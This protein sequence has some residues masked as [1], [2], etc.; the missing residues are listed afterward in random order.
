[1]Y[2]QSGYLWRQWHWAVSYSCC[3]LGCVGVNVVLTPAA[4]TSAA[5]AAP[6]RAAALDTV[7]MNTNTEMQNL[8]Q[9]TDKG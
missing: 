5:G 4:A 8:V 2:F 7:S 9:N 3:W 6:T 1:M